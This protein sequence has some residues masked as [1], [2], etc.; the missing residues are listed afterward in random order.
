MGTG[1]GCGEGLGVKFGVREWRVG[2]K[3]PRIG[4]GLE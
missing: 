3:R 2:C 4:V 1:V